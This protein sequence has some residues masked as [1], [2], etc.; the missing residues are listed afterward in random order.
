MHV[1]TCHITQTSYQ[2]PPAARR[3][4]DVLSEI[5]QKGSEFGHGA[6]DTSEESSTPLNAASNGRLVARHRRVLLMDVEDALGD[7]HFSRELTKN[8]FRFAHDLLLNRAAA[9]NRLKRLQQFKGRFRRAQFAKRRVDEF[10]RR[11]LDTFVVSMK[12]RLHFGPRFRAGDVEDTERHRL[13]R[14]AHDHDGL[15]DLID[16]AR[17]P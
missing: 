11:L 2:A 12:L 14:F 1:H 6:L 7:V 16:A 10:P 15:E 8:V 5:G 3:T 9:L 13:H 17:F 4:D